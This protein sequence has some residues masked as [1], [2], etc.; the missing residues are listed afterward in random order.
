MTTETHICTKVGYNAMIDHCPACIAQRYIPSKRVNDKMATA[1]KALEIVDD[2]LRQ[3]GYQ[4]DS[5]TRHNLAIATGFVK[6]AS[7]VET[8]REYTYAV[9]LLNAWVN[10]FGRPQG[11][12]PYNDLMG[13]LTQIDNV[14]TGLLASDSEPNNYLA[15]I[16][17]ERLTWGMICQCNCQA[18]V[19]L[20][21]VI[22]GV[23]REKAPE[24]EVGRNHDP[25]GAD[26][27]GLRPDLRAQDQ[28]PSENGKGDV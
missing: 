16:K 2:L 13:V 24:T 17:D 12:K 6:E 28:Q 22:R 27:S 15:K 14:V 4:E 3:S 23:P 19:D 9:G 11:F 25:S 7:Q 5:S 8:S 18:C 26:R 20:D 10:R 21:C 1:L